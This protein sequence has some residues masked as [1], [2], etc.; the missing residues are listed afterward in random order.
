MEDI[1]TQVSTPSAITQVRFHQLNEPVFCGTRLARVMGVWESKVID[2]GSELLSWKSLAFNGTLPEGS[3]IYL[4]IETVDTKTDFVGDWI[5]PFMNT[6]NSV[7]TYNGQYIKIRLVMV[8]DGDLETQY[9]YTAGVSGP[10]INWIKLTGITSSNAAKFYTRTFDLEFNPKYFLIT[11]EE[12]VPEGSIVRYAVTNVDTD[13]TSYYQYVDLNNITTLN[14]LPVTGNKLKVLIEMS[15][16]SGEDIVI[17][18]FAVMFGGEE[19]IGLN[20]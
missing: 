8:F 3:H 6:S 5:G 12:T 4:Y 2:G 7:I 11:A 13:D 10:I 1:T 14:T 19:Q 16:S 9:G 20:R 17:D 15:G 18:E